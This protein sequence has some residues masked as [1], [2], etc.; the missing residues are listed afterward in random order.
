MRKNGTLSEEYASLLTYP[1]FVS[2]AGSGTALRMKRAAEAG[3]LQ[4]EQ[5]FF[6]GVPASRL[7]PS[8]PDEETIL[9]QG[10]IDVF[11]EEDGGLILLDYKTDRVDTPE[12]LKK[13]YEAQLKIYAEA[14]SQVTGLAVKESIIYSFALDHALS[15]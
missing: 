11:W 14:L 13:R 5:P 8:F 3:T 10:V 12:E 15:L 2:F 9:V 1:K 6:I 4:R 7:D